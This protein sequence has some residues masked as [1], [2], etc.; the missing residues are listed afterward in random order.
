MI[1]KQLYN[2]EVRK[3]Q[4]ESTN[5]SIEYLLSNNVYN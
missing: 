5:N 2:Q 1:K 4:S 3:I